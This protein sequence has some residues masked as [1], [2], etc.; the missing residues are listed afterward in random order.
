LEDFA[1]MASSL[2]EITKNVSSARHSRNTTKQKQKTSVM[3]FMSQEAKRKV[4]ERTKAVL[5]SFL[6]LFYCGKCCPYE[7]D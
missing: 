1:A 7:R 3:D 2:E 5:L 4:K 6:N